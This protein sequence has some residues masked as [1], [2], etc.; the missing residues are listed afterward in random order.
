MI[1]LLDCSI[2]NSCTYQCRYCISKAVPAKAV[3]HCMPDGANRAIYS[4]CGQ[5]LKPW[6]LTNFIRNHFMPSEV[7]IQLSGGEPLLHDGIY[8]L[9]QFL[10]Y[11]AAKWVINTNG[12]QVRHMSKILDLDKWKCKWRCSWHTE[13]RNIESFLKDIEIL[14]KENVLVNY[15][16]TPWKI[17]TQEIK[18]D[19][20]DLNA[21]GYKFE[22]TAFQGDYE[23]KAWDKNSGIYE[24]YITAFTDAKMP[25]G[26][27]NYL[28]I[29][30]NGDIMRCHKVN[31][32]N[33]YENKL[34]ERYNPSLAPCGYSQN[35][36]TSCGLVQALYLLGM[37]DAEKTL[38]NKNG[39]LSY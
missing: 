3:N 4:N 5:S 32:G 19:I 17:E 25:M 38:N 29:Q 1:T 24:N 12:N 2:L 30:P 33:V 37:L 8:E 15:I 7:I 28:A 22:V 36:N 21:C 23:G 31:V 35:G 18:K 34:R 14:P 39:E 13:F 6:A 16:A 26:K 10:D 11:T 27:V 20:A 9:V